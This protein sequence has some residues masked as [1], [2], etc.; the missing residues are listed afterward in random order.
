M[1]LFKEGYPNKNKFIYVYRYVHG[2]VSKGLE[3]VSEHPGIRFTGETPNNV[4]SY[5]F[6]GCKE[7]D[8][9]INCKPS[10]LIAWEYMADSDLNYCH[11][12]K[13]VDPAHRSNCEYSKHSKCHEKQFALQRADNRLQ[14]KQELKDRIELE[15]A[16]SVHITNWVNGILRWIMLLVVILY[17]FGF[18]R[19]YVNYRFVT[20]VGEIVSPAAERMIDKFGD[21]FVKGTDSIR[22]IVKDD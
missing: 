17:I 13:E 9:F 1:R 20:G 12:C 19:T 6:H 3:V 4:S 15:N 11:I 8:S 14:H 16:G 7:C 18:V 5:E 10:Q 21:Q 2:S 22:K